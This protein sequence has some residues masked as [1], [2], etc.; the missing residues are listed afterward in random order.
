LVRGQKWGFEGR[1]PGSS[2][3][4][5]Q[6]DQELTADAGAVSLITEKSSENQIV[7]VTK[8]GMVNRYLRVFHHVLHFLVYTRTSSL[9]YMLLHMSE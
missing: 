2:R 8:K 3:I 9:T 5:S 4:Q 1:G 6:E 7:D